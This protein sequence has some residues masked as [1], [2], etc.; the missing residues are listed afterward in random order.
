[1][2]S[3]I[4]SMLKDEKR[5]RRPRILAFGSSNTQRIFEGMHWFDCLELGIKETYPTMARC[6]NSG[7]GGNTAGCMLNR[8]DDEAAMYKPDMT[9]ITVG[10]NDSFEH[11]N[12]SEQEFH[13]NLTKLYEKLSA[14]G[15]TLVYQTYY[16]FDDEEFAGTDRF[17]RYMDVVRNVA[18][19]T[20]SDLVDHHKRW[21]PFQQQFREEYKAA[22]HDPLHVNSLGNMIMGLDLARHFSLKLGTENP[23]FWRLARAYHKLMDVA[24]GE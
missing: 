16:A 6:I 18:A 11:N 4:F 14:L 15:S 9:F 13:D 19:E 23:P 2:H 24:N 5:A 8:F 17:S 3:K 21:I 20:G 7:V 10:G 1:M 22:M 12:V